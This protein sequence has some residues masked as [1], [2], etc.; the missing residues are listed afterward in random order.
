MHHHSLEEHDA[1]VVFQLIAQEKL[2]TFRDLEY[3]LKRDG[4]VRNN[5]RGVV[6]QLVEEELVEKQKAPIQDFDTYY[7]SEGGF[8][9]NR[10]L[11]NLK[12]KGRTTRP[13][14]H[15]VQQ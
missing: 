7:L 12:P 1:R 4:L 15:L 8:T 10:T 2:I 11:G 5:L 6:E 14:E 3:Q 13:A 9:A